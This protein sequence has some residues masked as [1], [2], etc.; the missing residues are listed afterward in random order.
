MKK[1]DLKLS[2]VEL[3]VLE[4]ALINEVRRSSILEDDTIYEEAILNKVSK[5]INEIDA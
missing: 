5:L 3:I 2:F 1:Y 4:N